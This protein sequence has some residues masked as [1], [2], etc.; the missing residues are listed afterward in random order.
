MKQYTLTEQYIRVLI[1][2]AGNAIC[3]SNVSSDEWESLIMCISSSIEMKII[4]HLS[5]RNKFPEE[6]IRV[7]KEYFGIV[8]EQNHKTD[9]EKWYERIKSSVNEYKSVAE[10]TALIVGY[11]DGMPEDTTF[12]ADQ[13]SQIFKLRY[14]EKE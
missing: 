14:P 7:L 12:T 9:F 6:V 10:R 5:G 11:F 2:A 8:E 13:I 3:E 4:D 1:C